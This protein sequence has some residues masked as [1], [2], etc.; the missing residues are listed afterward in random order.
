MRKFCW[1]ILFLGCVGCVNSKNYYKE[2]VLDENGKPVKIIEAG[3]TDYWWAWGNTAIDG[4]MAVKQQ[5]EAEWDLKIGAEIESDQ[6]EAAEIIGGML[7]AFKLGLSIGSG[8]P[9][10]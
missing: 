8:A 5:S 7:E 2:T 9:I 4:E 6:G 3:T 1:G 10:Q